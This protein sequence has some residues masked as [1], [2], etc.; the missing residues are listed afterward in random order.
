MPRAD[1]IRLACIRAPQVGRARSRAS[2]AAVMLGAAVMVVA[3]PSCGRKATDVRPPVALPVAFSSAGSAAMPDRWWTAFGD[4]QLDALVAEALAGNFTL[5]VAWDRLDQARA[6]AN[7]AEAPLRPTLDGTAEA[8]RA[9]QRT[10]ALGQNYTTDL[11]LGLL[12]GYEVDLWGRIRSTVDA[13]RLDV[14]ASASDLQAAAITLAAEVAHTWVALIEQHAQRRILAEQLATNERYLDVITLRFRRGQVSAADMLQQRQLV[15]STRGE[16][17]LVESTIAVLANRLAVLLGRPPGTL[18]VTAPESL[19]ALPP[20]PATGLPADWIRRRP[21]VAAA[22]RRVE[23]ADRRLAAAIADQF[24][25]LGL[26]VSANTSAEQVRDLFDNWLAS[27]AANLTAP[28]FD[29][30]RRAAEV[31][32]TRA[33]VSERLNTYGK[34]VLESLEEVEDALAQEAKQAAYVASLTRQLELAKDATDR[35]RDQYTL[36]GTDFVRYLTTLL[37]YQRLQRTTLLAER[38]LVAFRIDLYRALAG[39]WPMER[40][41]TTTVA[42]TEAAPQAPEPIEA[43]PPQ[44]TALPEGE[45]S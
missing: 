3:L 28:L 27:L 20:T 12:A 40:P 39:G 9:V 22:E 23:A 1:R 7:I 38:E 11:S 19:P 42:G 36:T 31:Q 44:E 45:G 13:A 4:T 35:V 26:T 5:R 30:G 10:P 15:E 34:V 43:A 16:A 41:P 32:R 24:P 21:D 14:A 37:N 2:R 8:S 17:R 25:R 6:V 18:T 29:G 33:V